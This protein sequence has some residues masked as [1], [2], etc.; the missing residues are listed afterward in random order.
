MDNTLFS[1]INKTQITQFNPLITEGLAVEYLKHV[2]PYLDNRIRC[3][4]RDFPPGLTYDGMSQ[5][6]PEETYKEITR[7]KNNK[8]QYEIAPSDIY[9]VK[10]H[11]SWQGK[12][13]FPR[14]I[15]LPFVRSG[16]L[17]YLRGALFAV[18]V[19]LADKSISVGANNLFIPIDKDKITFERLVQNIYI[20]GVRDSVYVVWA[21][22]YKRSAKSLK[23]QGKLLMKANSTMAHYLF[24]KYGVTETFRRYA[25]INVD[26]GYSDTIN[27]TTHPPSEWNICKSTGIKP[28][29]LG[30]VAY[31]PSEIRLAV[32]TAHWNTTV[33]GLIAGFFY[34]VDFFPDRIKPEWID[35]TNLWCILLGH[36]IF[37]SDVSEG[38]LADDIKPHMESIDTYLDANTQSNLMEGGIYVNDFY[39]FMAHIIE[40]FAD[41][42]MKSS[43]SVATM[44]GKRLTLLRYIL[45]PI[46]IALNKWVFA[47]KHNKFVLSEDSINDKMNKM[48]KPEL[49]MSIN[50][51]HGEVRPISSSSD[52]KMF[53]ITTTLVMQTN[54][55]GISR[56]NA[57]DS[58]VDPSKFLDAS[59]AAVGQ[60]A[61]VQKSEPSG[62]G[63]LNP[64][65]KPD[66]QGNINPDPV[67][68]ELLDSV[69]VKIRR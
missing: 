69:Q 15:F 37:A 21:K 39:D 54:S 47:L 63:R 36:V 43:D 29:G 61:V 60:Y 53:N 66:P 31:T 16:G 67:D 48:L 9:M 5:C 33:S 23:A 56:S 25:G 6:T 14:N 68:Q 65:L 2:E 32:K 13:L 8:Q 11:F 35:A 62:R 49:I 41:R 51:Q 50:H 19:V 7:R 45:S 17:M 18:N 22:I 34:C 4:S 27:E 44:Y 38:K 12:K 57:K 10:L 59:V 40:T 28:A 64:T 24:A 55:S 20:N 52:N 58:L 42:I 26:I 1:H 3:L 30:R 46:T